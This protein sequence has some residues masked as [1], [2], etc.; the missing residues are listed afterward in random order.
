MGQNPMQQ[1]P[2][3]ERDE[4]D[5]DLSPHSMMTAQALHV[6]AGSVVQLSWLPHAKCGVCSAQVSLMSL[7][8][9]T[10]HGLS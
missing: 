2:A 8:V 10:R 1:T 6:G 4:L 9:K 5:A 3:L 7:G